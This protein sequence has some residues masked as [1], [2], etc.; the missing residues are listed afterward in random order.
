MRLEVK[1]EKKYR[2]FSL[3]EFLSKFS[4]GTK[5]SFRRRDITRSIYGLFEG[6]QTD[7]DETEAYHK[8]IICNLRYTLNDLFERYEYLDEYGEWQPFGVEES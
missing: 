1:E 7:K 6:Y 4:I 8:I 5:I 2:P 3:E